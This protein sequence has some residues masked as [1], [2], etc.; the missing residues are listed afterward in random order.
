MKRARKQAATRELRVGDVLTVHGKPARIYKVHPLGTF[1]VET[2]D[3]RTFR[4]TGLYG[5]RV[6]A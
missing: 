5:A 4:V 2:A 6:P 3:G 1:D